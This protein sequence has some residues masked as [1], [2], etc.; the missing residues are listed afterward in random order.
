MHEGDTQTISLRKNTPNTSYIKVFEHD[1]L[2][3]MGFTDKEL[4]QDELLLVVKAEVSPTKKL[5]YLGFGK[6]IK[7]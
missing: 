5:K 2:R 1:W 3:Y 6:P 4:E 7:K